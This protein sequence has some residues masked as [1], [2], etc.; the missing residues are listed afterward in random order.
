MNV[1][2]RVRRS[3]AWLK[4]SAPSP[5]DL[6]GAAARDVITSGF[7]SYGLAGIVVFALCGDLLRYSSAGAKAVV[8]LIVAVGL[9]G[10][11]KGLAAQTNGARLAWLLPLVVGG[12]IVASRIGDFTDPAFAAALA[13]DR[14][15]LA[16]QRDMLAAQPRR[17]DSPDLF[18]A[19]GCRPQGEGSVYAPP[20]RQP[21]R[22]FAVKAQEPTKAALPAPR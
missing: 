20:A 8:G 16:V 14:R 10:L 19:L 4:A 11:H 3:S 5:A 9:V 2:D 6:R 15:C 1:L 18:Q 13:N 21:I 17:T 12:L 7:W 22:R